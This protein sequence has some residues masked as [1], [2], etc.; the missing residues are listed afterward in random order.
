[1]VAVPITDDSNAESPETLTLGL[2]N[3]VGAVLGHAS[4]TVTIGASDGL[5]TG[6]PAVSAGPDAVVSEGDGWIDLSVTLSAPGTGPVSV[7]YNTANAGAFDGTA[8]NADYVG[9]RGTLTFLPGEMIKVVR[10]QILD[11]PDVEGLEAFTLNLSSPT[12]GATIARAVTRVTIVD[13]DGAVTLASIQVTPAAPAI[14][15]GA[16]QQ[17]TAI[18]TYSDTST[19]DLTSSVT[20]ASDTPAVAN[21]GQ[22]GLAHALA[23]GTTTISAT[24]GAVS[25]GTQ[26]TVAAAALQSIAV[27]PTAPTIAAGAD[28][29][30]EA[31]GTYTDDSTADLT[32]TVAWD[33]ANPAVATIAGSG[34]AHALSPGAV[35]ISATLGDVSGSTLL[36]VTQRSTGQHHLVRAE[37][38]PG[39]DDGRRSTPRTSRARPARLVR[40]RGGERADRR[41]GHA[42]HGGRARRRDDRSRSA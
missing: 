20:W 11:C 39:R 9:D 22:G 2:S 3:P 24:L 4:G 31:T 5:A 12:G 7:F 36:T 32:S 17:F 6:A 26:L 25:G 37:L 38:R 28:K 42:G 8:C 33:S 14:P 13:N 23:V 19:A 29:Q 1:M 21:I 40:R 10:I 35:T 34:L 30:F 18:G 27:T 15:A 16:Q 41:L